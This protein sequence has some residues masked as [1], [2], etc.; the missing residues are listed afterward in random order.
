[1][2][3]SAPDNATIFDGVGQCTISNDDALPTISI[4]DVNLLEGDVGTKNFTFTVTLSKPNGSQVS[5]DFATADG[6]ALSPSDYV[7][8]SGSVV[9]APGQTL[10]TISIVV[11]GEKAAEAHSNETFYVNLTSPIGATVA[12]GQGLGTIASDD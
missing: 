2:Q 10:A 1:V 5:V 9:F 6:S 11:V 7:A 4:N 12:D 8:D 3:L